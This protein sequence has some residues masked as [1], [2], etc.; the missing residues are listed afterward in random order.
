MDRILISLKFTLLRN[1]SKGLRLVGWIFGALFVLGTWLA[2]IAASSDDAR[3]SVLSL[4][5]AGWVLG[6]ALG[7]VLLS[8]SGA[9]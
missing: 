5:F 8:G 6:A 4:A 3:G 2:V 1:S 9:L 7:P